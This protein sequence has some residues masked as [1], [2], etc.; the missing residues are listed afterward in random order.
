MPSQGYIRYPSIFLDQIVFVSED[1]LWLVSADGGRAE[2][3]TTSVG[4][5]S[6]PHFS[7]DGQQ[8]AFVGC[9]EGPC[10]VYL[11]P[12]LG[13]EV[14][15]LTYQVSSCRVAGWTPNGTHVL[16]ASRAEQFSS[17]YETLF[18][19]SPHG[20]LPEMLP[21]GEA[22]TIAYSPHGG[23]VL[24][25]YTQEPAY[26]KRYR[27]G[28]VGQL[29]CDFQ[30]SGGFTR[31][32]LPGNLDSP[33]W[34]GE[35]LYF[36]S[37]H[38]GIGNLYSCTPSGED[39]QRHSQH[40]D[41][42]ARNLS[43]DG[44]RLIYHAG[45]DLYLFDPREAQSRRL[46][47]VLPSMRTQRQ[48]TF[49]DAEDYLDTYAL[50]P[51]G[52]SL[53]LTTRGKAFT[54]GNWEGPVIQQ[55]EPDGV[56]YRFLQWLFDGKRL[57][58]ICDAPG[59]ETLV[60]VDPEHAHTPRL[61]S[62]ID[63]GR[64]CELVVSPVAAQVALTNHRHE[65]M[66]IDLDTKTAQVLDQSPFGAISGPAWSPDG[67]WLAYSRPVGPRHWAITLAR[68]EDYTTH[69]VTIPVLYDTAP[70]FDP[71]GK[72]LYFLGYRIFEPVYDH[73]R[74][75]LGFPHGVKPYLILLRHDLTSPFLPFPHALEETEVTTKEQ[76][77]TTAADGDSTG[78]APLANP[79]QPAHAP[80]TLQIDL[81]GI[82]E[83]VLPFPVAEG[84]YQQVSG[85]PG[86]VL[87]SAL[88]T[89]P[90]AAHIFEEQAEPKGILFCYDFE[91]QKGTRLLEGI[92][93]FAL[94]L[95]SKWLLYQ[96]ST[97]TRLRVIKAGEQPDEGDEGEST[98]QGVGAARG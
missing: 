86:K 77:T 88:P 42:Y 57:V 93:G 37:D 4:E 6:H 53:A 5:V 33:C 69:Q 90:D 38:D 49:V 70:A 46:E 26:W 32:P 41:F 63:C 98:R 16:Y 58:A 68:L 60:L 78:E 94:S 10:E 64:V 54:L 7:P 84:R 72:Y 23:I 24:G 45:A 14:R 59:R 20:G 85:I 39:L 66:L 44:S 17:D 1:D 48:R 95:N 61:L 65:L 82:T 80:T 34:V 89:E 43:T 19:V 62:E 35:R 92:S 18:C 9:E 51:K 76:T 36:L 79:G 71:D 29:W 15:R 30:G 12:A 13:A 31:L 56:R 8:I 74:F 87:F 73:L 67:R 27:D 50:H 2:R 81:D 52:H 22:S 96:T 55:G 97:D 40:Q 21:F 91:E 28:M 47:V 75:D 3:L 83:R 25:R 11:M